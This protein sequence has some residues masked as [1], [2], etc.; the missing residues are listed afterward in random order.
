MK[1][2]AD[3]DRRVAAAPKMLGQ[4]NCVLQKGP[5]W[6]GIVHDARRIGAFAAEEGRARGVADRIIAKRTVESHA[7][8]RYP[9][10]VGRLDDRMAVAAEAIVE[11]VG[12]DQ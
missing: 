9:V 4:H 8:L 1:D 11:I 12:N 2:L 7:A 5:R 6:R 3:F 10:D